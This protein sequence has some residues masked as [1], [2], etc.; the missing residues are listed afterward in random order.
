MLVAGEDGG[1]C[2]GG[3]AAPWVWES[4]GKTKD[5]LK[6]LGICG[7]KSELAG[8]EEWGGGGVFP[9]LSRVMLRLALQVTC[10]A[11]A[12]TGGQRGLFTQDP[13]AAALGGTA[14]RMSPPPGAVGGETL[15]RGG[16]LR[17]GAAFDFHSPNWPSFMYPDPG[18]SKKTLGIPAV[19]PPSPP[20]HGEAAGPGHSRQGNTPSTG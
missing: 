7:A 13:R 4:K 6:M 16:W 19:P 8:G 11:Q 3:R 2:S 5:D 9:S 15:P 17:S 18:T 10:L 12:R 1:V 20:P 14:E